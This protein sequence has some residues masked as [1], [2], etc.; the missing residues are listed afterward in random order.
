MNNLLADAELCVKC[1]LLS[2]H[3]Q[4]LPATAVLHTPCSLK[5]AMRQGQGALKLLQQIPTPNIQALPESQPCCGSAGTYMLEH[6]AMAEDLLADLLNTA[7]KAK[8]KFLVSSNIGCTLHIRAG[9]AER[10][11]EVEVLHPIVLLA[12]QLKPH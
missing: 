3:L 2:A 10:S 5:N 8:P 7:L 4:A 12:R 11:I 1:G 9:L 6:P